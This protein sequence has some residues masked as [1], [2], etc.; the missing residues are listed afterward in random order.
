MG[1]GLWW[2]ENAGGLS[3]TTWGPLQWYMDGQGGD[4]LHRWEGGVRRGHGMRCRGGISDAVTGRTWGRVS[5]L[6]GLAWG[7][8]CANPDGLYNE[9]EAGGSMTP[10]YG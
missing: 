10:P 2:A 9:G 7:N 3:A 6:V 4:G 1:F 5:E 8:E